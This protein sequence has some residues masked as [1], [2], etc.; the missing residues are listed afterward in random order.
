MNLYVYKFIRDNGNWEN[1]DM[2]M[3]EEYKDCENKL[4]LL[5]KERYYI[6]TLKC[7]LNI[8]IPSRGI[9]EIQK[10]YYKKNRT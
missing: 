2:C 3:I 1:W 10:E 6:E 7:K 9:K 4:Q 5:K 8:N